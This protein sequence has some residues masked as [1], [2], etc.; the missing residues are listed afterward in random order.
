MQGF[1]VWREIYL[2]HHT[3]LKFVK[4]GGGEFGVTSSSPEDLGVRVQD[5]GV[6]A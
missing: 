3:T 5:L 4:L 6:R 1:S 2:V